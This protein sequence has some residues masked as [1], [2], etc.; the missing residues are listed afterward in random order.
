MQCKHCGATLPEDANFCESC[1][2]AVQEET[3]VWT[4]DSQIAESWEAKDGQAQPL[5]DNVQAANQSGK[6]VASLVLG[7]IA[8]LFCGLPII[9]VPVSI[10]G[11]VLAV[12]ARKEGKSGLATAGLVL[13]IISLILSILMI[14]VFFSFFLLDELD[15]YYYY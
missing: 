11:L 3:A 8:V 7:I 2:A 10:V 4:A 1:G 6:A 13:S 15:W 14:F 5:N 12:M 9:S